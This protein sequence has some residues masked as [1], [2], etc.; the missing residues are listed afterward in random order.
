MIDS[1]GGSGES[2]L[3][4]EAGF[5]IWFAKNTVFPLFPLDLT[6]RSESA[7]KMSLELLESMKSKDVGKWNGK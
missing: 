5:L 7:G 6:T 2:F 3:F 1:G 4:I